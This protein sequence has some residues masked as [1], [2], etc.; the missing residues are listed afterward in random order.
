MKAWKELSALWVLLFPKVTVSKSDMSFLVT[1]NP[2]FFDCV[3]IFIKISMEWDILLVVARFDHEI[4]CQLKEFYFSF[5]IQFF[6]WTIPEFL[7]EIYCFCFGN[8]TSIWIFWRWKNLF[9][10][11]SV[12]VNTTKEDDAS[13]KIISNKLRRRNRNLC[14]RK[15]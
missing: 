3:P 4:F 10:Y 13:N 12:S 14:R 15:I 8:L 6:C 1:S 9:L 5:I 2:H 11:I 7:E